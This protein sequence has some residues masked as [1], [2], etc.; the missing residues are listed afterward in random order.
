MDLDIFSILVEIVVLIFAHI[1]FF[2]FLPQ[3]KKVSAC[4]KLAWCSRIILLVIDV[5]AV[6]GVKFYYILIL[7]VVDILFAR[8]GEAIVLYFTDTKA[9]EKERIE[10]KKIQKIGESKIMLFFSI[11][12]A[13]LAVA[14]TSFVIIYKSNIVEMLSF[15]VMW[16]IPTCLS[17]LAYKNCCI[18][19]NGS[20]IIYHDLFGREKRF[21]IYD[22]VITFV[23]D[24]IW[25]TEKKTDRKYH[26]TINCSSRQMIKKYY[27]I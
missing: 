8:I 5:L 22:V 17:L 27:N 1:I 11:C 16:I 7:F 12:F 6:C 19:L 15:A 10:I 25:I 26:V 24:G 9:E 23:I 4:V 20:E 18:Y 3:N 14:C 13:S 21:K 2:D